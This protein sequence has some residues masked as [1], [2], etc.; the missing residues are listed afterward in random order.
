MK[1]FYHISGLDSG[2]ERMKEEITRG[3]GETDLLFK[4]TGV[5]AVRGV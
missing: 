2:E 4:G 1:S 5:G 3:T